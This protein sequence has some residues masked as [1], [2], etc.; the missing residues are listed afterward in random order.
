MGIGFD[1]TSITGLMRQQIAGDLI[2]DGDPGYD[3][4]RRVWNGLDRLLRRAA[5]RLGHG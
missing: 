4:A 1:E 2:M 5:S 3:E